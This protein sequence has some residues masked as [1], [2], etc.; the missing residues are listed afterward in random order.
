MFCVTVLSS[1]FVVTH[2]HLWGRSKE[3]T[4]VMKQIYVFLSTCSSASYVMFLLSG[5]H[6]SL[7]YSAMLCR[8]ELNPVTSR[9]SRDI[10]RTRRGSNLEF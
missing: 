2:W 7:K 8:Y 3:T 5:I 4:H 9:F 10:V 6:I 1:L